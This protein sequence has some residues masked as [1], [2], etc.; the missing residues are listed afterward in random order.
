MTKP[1]NGESEPAPDAN[2]RIAISPEDKAKAAKWFS[3]ARDLGEKRQFDYAIEYYVNGLEF[4]PN[5][6]E[7]ACKPLHG[8][9][10]ARHQFGGKKPGL[11]DTMK[12]SINDKNPKKALLN[13][14]W[15]FGHDPD[16]IDYAEGIARAANKLH[17][18]EVASW[19]AGVCRKA[20]DGGKKLVPKQLQSLAKL[21]EEIAD[22]ASARGEM[23]FA[24]ESLQ[25][26]IDVLNLWR[27]KAPRDRDA[28]NATRD[29]ST[30]LTIVR[31]QYQEGESFRDSIADK[32]AQK[33]LH[34]LQE[35]KQADDRV[36]DLIAKSE[37]AYREDPDQPATLNRLIDL[38]TRREVEED[39][40]RAIK[41]LLERFQGT[42]DYR[43]KHQ[44]DDIHMK[45]LRRKVRQ[46]QQT[47]DTEAIKQAHVVSLKYDLGV[48][49]ERIARY[50]TDNRVKYEY[51]IRLF[52]AGRFDDA[53]PVFQAARA[54]LKNRAACGMYLGRCFFRKGYYPQAINALT[55]EIE[56]YEFS[57]D[58]LAKSMLYWLGRS[59]EASGQTAA[60]RETYGKILQMDYNYKDVRAKLDGLPP[61]E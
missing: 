11:K 24:V 51:G 49:K 9:A 41:I 4:W 28:E 55:K 56:N 2:E 15:L 20:L 23:A 26:G 61:G 5:A 27:R 58:D 37:A 36:E 35:S 44:A 47:G 45:Q 17:A 1:K 29:L 31:G 48:F 57:D 22:R 19:A 43:H 3:R 50:P 12:R 39:E 59:Q 13:S 16:N 40:T 6:V 54:D 30:K 10:V 8:C 60:A 25:S 34:D 53:I 42:G 52:S 33:D 7:E 38:L 14:A 46:A 18:E 21:Y 32:D